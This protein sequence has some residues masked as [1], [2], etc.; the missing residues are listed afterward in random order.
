MKKNSVFVSLFTFIFWLVLCIPLLAAVP[1]KGGTLTYA[2][3]GSV[4]TLDPPYA[5]DNMSEEVNMMI[6]DNLL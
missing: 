1:Q 2:Q 3:S 6:Y 4:E 5:N